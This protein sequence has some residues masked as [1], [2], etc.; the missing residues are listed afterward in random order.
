MILFPPAKINL[1]LKVLKKRSDGY[2]EIETCMLAIPVTDVL[3]LTRSAEFIFKQTGI[4][5]DGDPESNLCVKAFRLFQK[6]YH[7]PNAYIHLRKQLPM[8]AGLGGGSADA[9]YVLRGL[10][11]L[12]D[13]GLSDDQLRELALE[14]GSDCPFF[15]ADSVQIARGTGGTLCDF[16]LD[17]SGYYLKVINPAIHVGTKE[18]YA[19]IVFSDASQSI[20]SIL[21]RPIE[22]WKDQLKND[23]EAHIFD[24]HPVIGKLKDQLYA[25]EG[26]VYAAMTGSGS[27][28]FGI[29]EKKPELTTNYFEQI[30]EL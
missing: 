18:A 11:S 25:D 8:G 15:I 26:A 1:G 9:S 6:R 21:Q 24:H 14:L 30:L 13:V 4:K 28:V 17:L 20:E 10:N 12:F 16:D 2:H 27:T 5:V 3:E 19:G 29:F 7:I 23:F 22:M